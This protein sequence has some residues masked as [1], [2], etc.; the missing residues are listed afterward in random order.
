MSQLSYQAL[1]QN[2]HTKFLV[3][4]PPHQKLEVELIEVSG[5]RLSD[6]GKTGQLESFSVTF[7][8][9]SSRFL[10]QAIYRFEHSQI[11]NFDLFIVPIGADPEHYVYEAVFNRP[12]EAGD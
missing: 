3:C 4:S 2:L 1:L 12:V 6:S 10:A 5:R 9:P 8:G 7:W 11:G